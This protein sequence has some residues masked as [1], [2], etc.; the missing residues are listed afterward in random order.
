M[1]LENTEQRPAYRFEWDENKN[2][3]NI[4]KHGF[5]FADAEEMFRGILFSLPDV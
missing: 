3:Q 2:R 1:P 4:K 5:D